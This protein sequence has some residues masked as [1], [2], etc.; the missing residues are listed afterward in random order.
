MKVEKIEDKFTDLTYLKTIAK[1]NNDFMLRVINTFISQTKADIEKMRQYFDEKNFDAIYFI[2]HKMKPSFQFV[3]IKELNNVIL[4]IET[5][6]KEKNNLELLPGLISKLYS[7][8]LSSV[9]ELEEET[10]KLTNIS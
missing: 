4:D 1:G 8:Y 10:V 2:A 7:I 5:F 9:K 6:S 3:G